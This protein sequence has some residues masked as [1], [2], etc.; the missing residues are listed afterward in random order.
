MIKD[1]SL[2]KDTE[3]MLNWFSQT[4]YSYILDS[5]SDILKTQVKE[6]ELLS[7]KVTSSPNWLSGGRKISEESNQIILVRAAVVFEFE[8][9]VNTYIK[10]ET[11]IGVFTLAGIELDKDSKHRV[12]LDINGTLKEFGSNGLLKERI[13]FE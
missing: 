8:L 3:H 1:F 6:S 11:L 7:F 4:P 13:Y 2:L 5:I 12:W 9:I 10:K